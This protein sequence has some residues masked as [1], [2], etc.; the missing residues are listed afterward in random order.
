MIVK[1]EH[2]KKFRNNFIEYTLGRK[3]LLNKK[4]VGKQC[5]SVT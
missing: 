3:R 5:P 2:M 1:K 4:G